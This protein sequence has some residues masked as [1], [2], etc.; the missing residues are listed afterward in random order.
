[1]KVAEALRRGIEDGIRELAS[2]ALREIHLR[3]PIDTG[4]LI[5]SIEVTELR[6]TAGEYLITI[7]TPV[8]YASIVE[9]GF[10]ILLDENTGNP[11]M[12]KPR[13]GV[14]MFKLGLEAVGLRAK[15]ILERNIRRRI[16]RFGLDI[17]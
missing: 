4:L 16:K 11:I 12:A 9:E 3:T 17:S 1:M 10:G 6:E 2:E 15:G 13:E 7:E 14:F 5:S 8:H